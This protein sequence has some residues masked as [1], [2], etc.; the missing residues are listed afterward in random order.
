MKNSN[1]I[2]LSCQMM[3]EFIRITDVDIQTSLRVRL[4]EYADALLNVSGLLYEETED[5]VDISGQLY[6]LVVRGSE[7]VH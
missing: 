4:S 7:W 2:I 6:N 5:D 3:Y 1:F